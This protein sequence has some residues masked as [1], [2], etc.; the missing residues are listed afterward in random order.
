MTWSSC[1]VAKHIGHQHPLIL[2]PIL[3]W[4]QRN[5]CWIKNQNFFHHHIYGTW[6]MVTVMMCF[7]WKRSSYI[8]LTTACDRRKSYDVF[9]MWEEKFI[10]YPYLSPWHMGKLKC[11]VFFNIRKKCLSI[12]LT[13]TFTYGKVK[14]YFMFSECNR[15]ARICQ[16][17]KRKRWVESS[18][19][20]V[21]ETHGWGKITGQNLKLHIAEIGRKPHN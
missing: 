9:H 20:Q 2:Q 14:M 10:H 4:L 18:P 3:Q 6:Y 11:V 15:R 16:I 17:D 13:M 5:V 21:W 19:G 8:S 1:R 12:T 7:I